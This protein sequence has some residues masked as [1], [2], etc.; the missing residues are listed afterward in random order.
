MAQPRPNEIRGKVYSIEAG[1]SVSFHRDIGPGW[2]HLAAVREGG[3]LKVYVDG[4]LK[5]SSSEAGR[6]DISNHEPLLIG[7]GPVDYFSGKLRE[8]RVHARAL[9][10]DEV[11]RMAATK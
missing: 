2:K 10:P 8:V 1:T 7:F 5:A 11:K 9:R 6:Y 4:A 3:A